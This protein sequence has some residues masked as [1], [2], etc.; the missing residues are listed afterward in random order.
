VDDLLA[1]RGIDR[2]L[3]WLTIIAES[4]TARLRFQKFPSALEIKAHQ[5]EIAD[6]ADRCQSLEDLRELLNGLWLFRKKGTY[7]FPT[8]EQA[9]AEGRAYR[10]RRVSDPRHL[11]TAERT[12]R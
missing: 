11:P 2:Q 9:L 1:R 8:L 4:K 10:K 7:T 5:K 12:L 6:H 3:H